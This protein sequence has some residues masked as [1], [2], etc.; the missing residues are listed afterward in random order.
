MLTETSSRKMLPRF[1]WITAVSLNILLLTRTRICECSAVNGYSTVEG[2]C[3]DEVAIMRLRTHR[4]SDLA[5]SQQ[6]GTMDQRMADAA[7]RAITR[8]V[9]NLSASHSKES[10]IPDNHTQP[11]FATGQ[12]YTN[13]NPFYCKDAAITANSPR[14]VNANSGT[15]WVFS[16][17][18]PQT[19][20]GT[21]IGLPA[22]LSFNTS[23]GLITGTPTQLA[24]DPYHVTV[25]AT[26]PD[27]HGSAD[28]LVSMKIVNYPV[29]SYNWN[30]LYRGIARNARST[31]FHPILSG[32]AVTSDYV[33][34]NCGE[35]KQFSAFSIEGSDGI[36]KYD[37]NDQ[38]VSVGQQPAPIDIITSGA[39]GV[40]QVSS[41][42]V[43]V[44]GPPYWYGY[45]NFNQHGHNLPQ[46]WDWAACVVVDAGNMLI[47]RPEPYR[48]PD[49]YSMNALPSCLH[50]S[51]SSG[52]IGG[53]CNSSFKGDSPYHVAVT[54]TNDGGSLTMTLT[55]EVQDSCDR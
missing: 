4:P 34:R 32:C 2:Q 28:C 17:S 14:F 27:S 54:G 46:N 37:G 29:V 10:Q 31:G 9:S 18:T 30:N 41:V 45:E 24:N 47:P 38:S 11:V 15:P 55:I 16:Y 6:P 1:T 12:C 7:S 35:G 48:T 39:A 13:T 5:V 23:S 33:C 21:S 49:S 53:M 3:S 20:H 42:I 36:L 52:T 50:Y 44:R 25:T 19:I 51:P 43:T 26:D 40:Q 22:G 8:E